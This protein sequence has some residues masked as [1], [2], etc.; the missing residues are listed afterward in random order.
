MNTL[1]PC[2]FPGYS[3]LDFSVAD[4][5]WGS[6][7]DW[8]QFID[9]LHARGM[10]IILD[11]TVGTMSDLIGFNGWVPFQRHYPSDSLFQVPERVCPFQYLRI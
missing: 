1:I 7:A 11:F 8:V 9:T 6:I 2:P 3:P 5:H 10:Y 4:P